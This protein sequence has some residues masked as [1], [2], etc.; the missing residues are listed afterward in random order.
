MTII[1]GPRNLITDV[2]GI[3]V[4]NA[5]D[6]K[7][8]TGVTVI[9]PDEPAIASVD[10]RGGAPGTRET[11]AL[12][13]SCL[14]D[15]IDA[16]VLTGGSVFGLDAAS[17]VTNWLAGQKR[18]FPVGVHHMPIVPAAVLFDM[19]N[20][21]NKNW[22][23]LP[24]HG[25][26]GRQA[27]Q[28]V[29]AD[30]ALGNVGA[31]LGARAGP[32]KGGLGSASLTDGLFTMGALAVVNSLGS[33]MIPGSDAF[34]AWPLERGGEFG[35]RR[36]DPHMTDPALDFTF[37]EPRPDNTTLVAIVTDA[38]LDRSQLKRLAMMAHDGMARA[39]RPIHTPFDGD[40]VFSLSTR[41][42]SVKD[43]VTDLARLGLMAADCV[44]RAV[45][46]GVY[47]ARSIPGFPSYWEVHAGK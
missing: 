19:S 4:G 20:G 15:R 3:K 2:A 27:V 33:P 39:I 12:D 18:G 9:L 17:A 29:T 25:E 35:G 46:R 40:S 23:N 16:V 37:P 34:W 44:A 7:A 32:L 28:T 8:I 10:V 14:V 47:E 6:E 21:G 43:G 5:E 1:P 36:P 13:A 38:D 22:G 31:G 26:L 24:P 45:C 30:F 11:D 42:V 41:R